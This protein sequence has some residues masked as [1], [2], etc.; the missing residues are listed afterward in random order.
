VWSFP[1]ATDHL[2]K[3]WPEVPA[4]ENVFEKSDSPSR[5]AGKSDA[6]AFGESLMPLCSYRNDENMYPRRDLS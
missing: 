1:C 2:K 5:H 4:T 3:S 6:I